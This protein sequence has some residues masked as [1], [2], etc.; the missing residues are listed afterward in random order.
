MGRKKLWA[1]VTQSRFPEGT[2]ARISAVLADGEDR[3]DFIREAVSKELARR[4]K[5]ART[6]SED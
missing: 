1:E 2:F 3:T 6:N 5:K 4:E